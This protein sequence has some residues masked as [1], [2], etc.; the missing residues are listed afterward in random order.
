MRD[1]TWK[2]GVQTVL[3]DIAVRNLSGLAECITVREQRDA[4]IFGIATDSKLLEVIFGEVQFPPG[5]SKNKF[6]FEI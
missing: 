1:T 3:L 6:H 5:I 4:E 2:W